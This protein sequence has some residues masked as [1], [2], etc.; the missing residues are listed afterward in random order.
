MTASC[1]MLPLYTV[2]WLPSSNASTSSSIVVTSCGDN[3][4]SLCG[5]RLPNGSETI[6]EDLHT[7]Q[8]SVLHTIPQAHDGDVNCARVA[9]LSASRSALRPAEGTTS[10]LMATCGDDLLVKVWQVTLE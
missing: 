6:E 10:L 7:M 4:V 5:A 1:Q 3:G 8:A 2:D 9:P